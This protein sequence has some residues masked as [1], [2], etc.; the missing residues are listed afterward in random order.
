MPTTLTIDKAGRVVL[1]KPVRDALQL[2]PGDSLELENSE[3]QIVLRPARGKGRMY[4][5]QGAWVFDSGKPVTADVVDQTIR[6]VRA[7]R[8][9]HNLG[10][11]K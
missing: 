2:S 3:D 7:E 1:P 11:F 4:K 8:D 5:K 10:K 9:R 6:R